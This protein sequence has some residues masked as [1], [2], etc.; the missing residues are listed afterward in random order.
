[1]SSQV[2]GPPARSHHCGS[3]TRRIQETI[4]LPSLSPTPRSEIKLYNRMN[5]VYRLPLMPGEYFFQLRGT[6]SHLRVAGRYIK[7]PNID[8][9]VELKRYI[10]AFHLQWQRFL[11]YHPI[12][13]NKIHG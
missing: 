4:Q 6:Q 3:P 11:G 13:M 2:K 1:M 5:F 7:T 9:E 10:Y 8:E 12:E